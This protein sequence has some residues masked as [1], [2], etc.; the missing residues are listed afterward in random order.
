MTSKLEHG[1][2]EQYNRTILSGCTYTY[3]C[4]WTKHS[5]FT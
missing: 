1:D 2:T 3:T 5:Y 4:N